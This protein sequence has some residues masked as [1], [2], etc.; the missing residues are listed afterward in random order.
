VFAPAASSGLDDRASVFIGTAGAAH[1]LP[2]IASHDTADENVGALN[3]I[4]GP[5]H[6][7]RHVLGRLKR[8]FAGSTIR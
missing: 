5:V 3:R 4:A 1:V 7:V 8:R 6:R 2:I